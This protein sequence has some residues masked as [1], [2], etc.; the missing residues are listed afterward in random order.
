MRKSR[1]DA[2]RTGEVDMLSCSIVTMLSSQ[3]TFRPVHMLLG[4]PAQA[5]MGG[6][7]GFFIAGTLMS[8]SHGLGWFL[9]GQATYELGACSHFLWHRTSLL[10]F[11]NCATAIQF[12]S[13]LV[14]GGS[15]D[16]D[17]SG[18]N[19]AL[20]RRAGFETQKRELLAA[21]VEWVF[22]EQ[23]SSVRTRPQL[24]VRYQVCA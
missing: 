4:L 24:E 15:S 20:G 14:G 16:A 22:C 12:R 13:P 9:T 11:A 3:H 1:T 6:L 21:G 18:T 19:I 23:T 7:F 8:P 2:D 17:W 10:V 5:R